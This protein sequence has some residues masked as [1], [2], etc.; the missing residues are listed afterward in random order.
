MSRLPQTCA[1]WGSVPFVMLGLSDRGHRAENAATD[2][3][4]AVPGMARMPT[5]SPNAPRD[6][7]KAHGQHEDE[8][9]RTTH[10]SH[11]T[12]FFAPD[13]RDGLCRRPTR[14]SVMGQEPRRGSLPR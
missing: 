11:G 5:A 9:D 3:V 13:R 1:R 12:P 2:L 8:P 10:R 7:P 4:A 6:D 14:R